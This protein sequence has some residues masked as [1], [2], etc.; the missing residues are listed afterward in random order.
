MYEQM[1]EHYNTRFRKPALPPSSGRKH[2][3]FWTP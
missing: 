2:L 1:Y 3:I